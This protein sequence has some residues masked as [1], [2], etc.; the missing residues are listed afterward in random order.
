MSQ[1]AGY[2]ALTSCGE[3]VLLALSLPPGL[4]DPTIKVPFQRQ[5]LAVV[6]WRFVDNLPTSPNNGAEAPAC[7]HQIGAVL[8]ARDQEQA[9]FYAEL[10]CL[11]PK[12][13]EPVPIVAFQ[14]LPKVDYEHSC[15]PNALEPHA[16]L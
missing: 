4:S 11:D 13:R 8:I 1:I 15:L 7:E 12:F 5:T 3:H 16:S 2:L 14:V 10:M 9:A 6:N